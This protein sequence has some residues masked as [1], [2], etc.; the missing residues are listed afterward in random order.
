MS[1]FKP[2]VKYSDGICTIERCLTIS[3][4]LLRQLLLMVDVPIHDFSRFEAWVECHDE[5]LHANITN[6]NPIHV[7]WKETIPCV[8]DE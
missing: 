2:V 6:T 3:P 5:E 7:R 4:I 8:K 1:G